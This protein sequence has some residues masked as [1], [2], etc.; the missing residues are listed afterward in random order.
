MANIH[1]IP[2]QVIRRYIVS[3]ITLIKTILYLLSLQIQSMTLNLKT[4][5]QRLEDII[6]Y[7]I[8]ILSS[9]IS[10]VFKKSVI[11]GN[12]I[13]NSLAN[14]LFSAVINKELFF[15]S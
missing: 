12:F 9:L 8:R 11:F 3:Y 1:M 2:V 7:R 10:L 4:G 13:V 14:T 6:I 15:G 5:N